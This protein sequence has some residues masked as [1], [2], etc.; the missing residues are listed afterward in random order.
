MQIKHLYQELKI[1]KTWPIDLYCDNHSTI[2]ISH[3]S[4]YH[5]KTKH[6]E[7][8]LYFVRN[9]VERKEIRISCVSIDN[10]PID[11]LTKALGKTKFENCV[12]LFNTYAIFKFQNLSVWYLGIFYL[13]SRL[14]TFVYSS[15][16]SIYLCFAFCLSSVYTLLST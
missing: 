9:M 3:N 6:F 13:F 5:T 8:H 1:L 4:M 12:K 11:I 2:K 16:E 7:I 15:F 14:K 10:Q